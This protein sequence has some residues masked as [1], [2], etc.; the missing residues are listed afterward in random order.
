VEFADGTRAYGD[1]LIGADGRRSAV[2]DHVPCDYVV[3]R[4]AESTEKYGNANRAHD[5]RQLIETE[6]CVSRAPTAGER[7]AL[8]AGLGVLAVSQAAGR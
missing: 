3:L 6:G 5:L 8:E 2:R 1:L 7:E 4:I